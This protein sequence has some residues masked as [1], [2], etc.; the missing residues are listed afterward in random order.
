MAT[1]YSGCS[2]SASFHM[3]IG[4]FIALS[5]FIW[6]QP[7]V[8]DIKGRVQHGIN[9]NYIELKD[10]EDM[11]SMGGSGSSEESVGWQTPL[12]GPWVRITIWD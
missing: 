5:V 11:A 7:S 10:S 6:H 1:I 9:T 4:G 2:L 12:T 8:H 3:K